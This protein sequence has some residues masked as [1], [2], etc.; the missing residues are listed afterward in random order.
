MSDRVRL[1]PAADRLDYVETLLDGAG[2]PTA[3]VQDK[4]D[5]F[6][7]GLVDDEPVGAGGVEQLGPDGLLRS[8]VVA[9]AERGRGY[10][11]ALVAALERAARDEGIETLYLLTTAAAE[12]FEACGYE[13]VAREAVPARVRETTQFASLCPDDATAM[14]RRL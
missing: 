8:V 14:C 13:P 9:P 5:C 4:P 6:H 11:T 1:R 7:I 12:F 10:G 3:D 2:L